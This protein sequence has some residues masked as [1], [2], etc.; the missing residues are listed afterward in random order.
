MNSS[1]IKTFLEPVSWLVTEL[2]KP[3]HV[4]SKFCG[5]V[6]ENFIF[7]TFQKIYSSKLL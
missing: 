6:A 1:P 4:L 2:G 5:D 7:F 3:V